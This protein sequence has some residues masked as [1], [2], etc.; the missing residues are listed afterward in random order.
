MG[1]AASGGSGYA[2]LDGG[3]Q[4]RDTGAGPQSDK[5]RHCFPGT[6]GRIERSR[7]SH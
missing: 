1:M 3:A 2:I 4:M 6:G 7:I 5:N